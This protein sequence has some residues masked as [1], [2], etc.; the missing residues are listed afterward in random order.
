M[1]EALLLVV[2]GTGG[3]IAVG[4]PLMWVKT[5]RRTNKGNTAVA[6]DR[7]E[8]AARRVSSA[9]AQW[10]D[11][12]NEAIIVRGGLDERGKERL[13]RAESEANECSRELYEAWLPVSDVDGDAV[14]S[15]N[16]TSR[17]TVTNHKREAL[18]VVDRFERKL[19]N[20][21][22]VINQLRQ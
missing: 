20:L 9:Q 17:K 6:V 2:V 10:F 3:V 7:F 16:D 15:Y 13:D 4:L 12:Q 5:R 22:A 21:D 8:D 14:A 19:A 1:I 11:L 18:A